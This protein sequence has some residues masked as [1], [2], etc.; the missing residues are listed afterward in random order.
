M[1]KSLCIA[2]SLILAAVMLPA[3][4]KKQGPT[5]ADTVMGGSGSGSGSR[6]GG[7]IIP[8]DMGSGDF[9]LN[10]AGLESRAFGDG[11]GNGKYNGRDMVEGVLPSV[12]FGFDS[13]SVSA[14]ERS[15]LQ[16]AADHLMQNPGD[17]LLIEGH[18]DWYGTAEYNLA[19]G[20][21]RANSVRDYLS[22]LGISSGR[23]ETLSK[24]SLEATSGLSKSESGEDRR[25]DLIILK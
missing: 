25:A 5:R 20:D 6:F 23:I 7:D 17:G 11:I 10:P 14:S 22:T 21:R 4:K 16:D 12:F 24:G 3:C 18:A 8:S 1:S 19:L 9:G 2:L 15:K 13:S